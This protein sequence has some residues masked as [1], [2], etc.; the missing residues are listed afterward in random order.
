MHCGRRHRRGSAASGL[1]ASCSLLIDDTL[2]DLPGVSSTHT[3]VKTGHCTVRL[4]ATV[5]GPQTIIDITELG[6]TVAGYR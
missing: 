1:C 3:V 5:T 2:E 6:Y 4:D